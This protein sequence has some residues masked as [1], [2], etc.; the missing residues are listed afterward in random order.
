MEARLREV[1]P[2]HQEHRQLPTPQ[3]GLRCFP[4]AK[5]EAAFRAK[6]E[7]ELVIF[8][9]A[10]SNLLAMQG[11]GKLPSLKA[12][13]AEQERLTQEQQR[14]YD[15]RASLKKQAKQI[16]TIKAN[17]DIFL[18]LG[19]DTEVTMKRTSQLE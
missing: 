17:V 18:S 5:D 9:A 15:E 8:D 16:D 11:D 13:Q 4:K 19:S 14:L 10:K 6:H 1:Q 12:L 3:A 2:P 7:A